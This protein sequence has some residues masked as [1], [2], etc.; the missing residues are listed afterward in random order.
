MKIVIDVPEDKDYTHYFKCM[1]QQ[2]D[3]T[4]NEGILIDDVLDKIRAEIEKEKHIGFTP[5]DFADGLDMALKIIDKYTA[6]S[7]KG[8]KE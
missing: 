1:S 5:Q 3:K 6:E 2:L 8:G 7:Q 4:L